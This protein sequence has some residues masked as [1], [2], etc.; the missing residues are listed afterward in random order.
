MPADLGRMEAVRKKESPPM[1][2]VAERPPR[3]GS[4][5]NPDRDIPNR[6]TRAAMLAARRGEGLPCKDADELLKELKS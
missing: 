3:K 2:K 4:R 1:G 6:K 5:P